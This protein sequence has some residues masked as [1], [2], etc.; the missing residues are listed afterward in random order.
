[1]KLIIIYGPPAVGK[2]T[3]AEELSRR[4]GFKILQNKKFLFQ[5][6]HIIIELSCYYLLGANNEI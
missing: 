5:E 4:T 2:L 1:M 3:V 6:F